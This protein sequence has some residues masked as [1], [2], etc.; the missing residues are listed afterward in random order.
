MN[1]NELG[2]PER[3]K[4]VEAIAKPKRRLDAAL[5]IV[6]QPLRPRQRIELISLY[7]P[8]GKKIR[9]DRL[10]QLSSYNQF[11]QDLTATLKKLTLI[12]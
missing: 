4:H 1:G 10:R 5:A 3:A 6:N 12:P 9:L 7:E 11:V 2:I 8:L